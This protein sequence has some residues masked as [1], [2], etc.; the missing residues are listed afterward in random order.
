MKTLVYSQFIGARY[1]TYILTDRQTDIHTHTYTYMHKHF[2]RKYVNSQF[3]KIKSILLNKFLPYV[4]IILAC[5][6][7]HTHKKS[8]KTVEIL[9][10]KFF[11]SQTCGYN[12]VHMHTPHTH[13]KHT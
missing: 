10:I 3:F 8:W 1:Y 7:T 6:R 2:G 12:Y 5:M 4:L 11:P 9:D 13:T